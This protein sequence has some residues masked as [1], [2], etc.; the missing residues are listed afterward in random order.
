MQRYS[1]VQIFVQPS[2]IRCVPDEM[3]E[4]AGITVTEDLSQCEVLFGIKEVPVGQLIPA[5]TYFFFSHTVKKQKYNRMLLQTILKKNITLID[6]ECLT[7]SE[8]NKQRIIA[9]G[10]YAGIVGTYNALWTY[11]KKY[12]MFDLKRAHACK[13]IQEMQQEFK[14]IQLPPVKI[15][16]TGTGKV[17]KGVV[18]VLKEIG[19]T[20]V[21]LQEFLHQKSDKPVYIVLRSQ[22]YHAHK[23]GLAWNAQNFHKNPHEYI[24]TFYPFATIADIM[25]T[26]AFW[27][28][29]APL[30]FTKED[31]QR[32][33]F[34][35]KVIADISCDVDGSVPCTVRTSTIT[36][37]VYD[38]DPLSRQEKAAF[39]DENHI[40]VMAIDNLPCELPYDASAYFGRQLID[41]VLPHLFNHDKDK[42]LERATIARNGQLTS[43]YSYLSDFVSENI[44]ELKY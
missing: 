28:P 36:N 27:H 39:S 18:E 10:R 1:Q 16:V 3:Y 43:Q 33:D 41:Q 38:Y 2:P 14:K 29:Q 42:I 34:N 24:S 11:G 31:M 30:L 9:F 13:D 37:P 5:K 19:I 20:E 35:I 17:G 8:I 15:V 23:D 44:E 22:D 12:K 32:K 25:I 26:S 21:S 6:Y 40:T 4:K 7:D